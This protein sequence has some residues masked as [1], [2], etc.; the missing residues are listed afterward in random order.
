MG[1]DVSRVGVISDAAS[2][3]KEVGSAMARNPS[4][5]S[6]GD[7]PFAASQ[8]RGTKLT[9]YVPASTGLFANVVSRLRDFSLR[10]EMRECLGSG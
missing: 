3:V 6:G 10:H 5:S 1:V 8:T 9:E 2:S 4:A 7:V